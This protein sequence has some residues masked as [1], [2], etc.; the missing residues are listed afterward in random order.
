MYMNMWGE[1]SLIYDYQIGEE[2]NL[3]RK[4]VNLFESIF[5]QKIVLNIIIYI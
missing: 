4:E 1:I 2:R 5:I 3:K